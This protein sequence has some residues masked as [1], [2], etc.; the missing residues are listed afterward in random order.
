MSGKYIVDT[1][2]I[3]KLLRSDKRADELFEQAD[4]IYIPSI[5]V[6]ELYY[7]AYNSTRVQENLRLF[8]DFISQYGVLDINT[9]VAKMYGEIKSQLKKDGINIPEND[10]WIA[11]LAKF[12]KYALITFDAHFERIDGIQVLS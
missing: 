9:S 1:N 5:V 12:H 8:S 10:L 3:T 6:G 7:G 4:E 11:A 2:V